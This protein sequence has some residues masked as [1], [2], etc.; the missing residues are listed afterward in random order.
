MAAPAADEAALEALLRRLKAL[1]YRFVAVTPATHQ[2]V[3]ARGWS[4]PATLRD[5]FGWSRR[6]AESDLDPELLAL[7]EAGGALERGADGLRSRVR[8]A[9][10]GG[11][12][13]LHSAF[14]PDESDAV[15]TAES[16]E[17]CSQ[18]ST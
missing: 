12:L 13:F 14:P 11:D 6:F 15:F 1:A 10:L 18:P 5:I 7:L 17:L 3:L 8:A 2:R 9:S 4:G 16:A